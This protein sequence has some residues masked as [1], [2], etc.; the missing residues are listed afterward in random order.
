MAVPYSQAPLVKKLALKPGSRMLVIA[1]PTG[2]RELLGELPA[3]A[4]YAE[5]HDLPEGTFDWI[6]LFV[7]TT[8]E[9]EERIPAVKTRVKPGGILWISFPR[10][11]QATDLNRTVLMGLAPRFALDIVTNVAV[12]D[13]W[14]AYRLKPLAAR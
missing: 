3:G 12:N 4:E 1:P 14:T 6:H 9:L 10:G 8:A 11:K 2:Y 7:T 5:T 13:D